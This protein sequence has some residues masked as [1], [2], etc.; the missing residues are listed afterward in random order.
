VAK[1]FLQRQGSDY[2]LTWSPTVNST[3]LRILIALAARDGRRVYQFDVCDAY[4]NADLL[5]EIYVDAPK[6]LYHKGT[7]WRLRKALP[8]LKQAGL[9]WY[10]NLTKILRGIGF[11]PT[12][13][14]PCVFVRRTRGKPMYIAI[15]VDDGLLV[16]DTPKQK[17]SIFKALEKV[18]KTQRPWLPRDF[19]RNRV[20]Q[21]PRWINL[22]APKGIHQGDP[23]ALRLHGVQPGDDT[24]D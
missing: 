12:K 4:L 21:V 15:H 1:G 17:E 24:G 3:N 7:V 11:Q 23:G 19:S 10:N 8:G 16:C 20:H 14:D 6:N 2:I 13:T 5:E 22:H 18:M 9:A